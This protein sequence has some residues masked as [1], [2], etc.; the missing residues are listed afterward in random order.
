MKLVSGVSHEDVLDKLCHILP[1]QLS[2]VG[3]VPV[4]IFK[5]GIQKDVGE[6]SD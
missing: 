4:I 1:K 5:I 3:S 2:F 6:G